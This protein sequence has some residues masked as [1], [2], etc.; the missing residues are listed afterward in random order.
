MAETVQKTVLTDLLARLEAAEGAD[1][2]L[3][4]EVL[5]A[6]GHVY[7]VAG[8]GV[9]GWRWKD[10]SF[11]HGKV[12]VTGLVDNALALVELVLPGWT[13]ARI[14]QDDHKL[15]HVELR[16]GYATSYN[17]VVIA[18]DGLRGTA[19]PALALLCAL[20]KALIAKEISDG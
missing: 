4:A 1:R 17:R 12:F 7:T 11:L 14:S 20:V 5:R 10:G 8:Q 9:F 15:W 6:T 18:P 16:E 2:E 3:D 19:T 13:V